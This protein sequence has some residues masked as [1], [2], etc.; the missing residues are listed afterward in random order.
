MTFQFYYYLD[1]LRIS[2]SHWRI[3][4]IAG[5]HVCGLN[6]GYPQAT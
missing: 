4:R 3:S 2:V 1:M 5:V 6:N